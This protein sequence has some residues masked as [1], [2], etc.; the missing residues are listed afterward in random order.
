MS[1][2]LI[3]EIEELIVKVKADIVRYDAR[4]DE[5]TRQARGLVASIKSDLEKLKDSIKALVVG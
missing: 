1:D 2:Q 4:Q 3:T 5:R